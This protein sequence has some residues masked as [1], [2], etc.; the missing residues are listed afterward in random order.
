[1]RVGSFFRPTH[2]SA[3]ISHI[4]RPRISA[5]LNECYI[6]KMMTIICGKSASKY[7]FI[8]HYFRYISLSYKTSFFI[9]H[10]YTFSIEMAHLMCTWQLRSFKFL[11][12]NLV[13]T[14][15]LPIILSYCPSFSIYT[16]Y[17]Y[18]VFSFISLSINLLYIASYISYILS[19]LI[20]CDLHISLHYLPIHFS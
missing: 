12:L 2:H 14:G 15:T 9:Y 16:V 18:T 10:L 8:L 5:L 6:N 20:S 11:N 1:M 4:L 3:N 19:V 13:W 7:Q 17:R